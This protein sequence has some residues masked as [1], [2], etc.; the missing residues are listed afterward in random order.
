MWRP[1][2]L[3]AEA[4][5]NLGPRHAMTAALAFLVLAAVLAFVVV[6]AQ[7]ALAQ[8]AQR[9]VGG[10]LVWTITADDGITFPGTACTRLA[11]VP[12]IAAAGGVTAT[13]PGPF[14]PYPGS[15]SVQAVGLTG[16][17][18]QVFYPDAPPSTATLGA[19]L[20][21]LG[22]VG[23]GGWLHD[24]DGDRVARLDTTVPATV[25]LGLLTSG[26]T[27]PAPAD[28][29]LSQCW[30][31]TEPGAVETGHDVLA[32]TFTG[33]PATIAPFS[34]PAADVL[35]PA[36]QWRAAVALQPWA[37]GAILLGLVATL[38]TWSRRTELAVYRAFGT[39]TATLTT[40]VAVELAL[41][42]APALAAAV[43][44]TTTV[45][46]ATNGGIASPVLTVA[47]TQ[48]A[49]AALAGYALAVAFTPLVLRGRVTDQLKDR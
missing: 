21:S 15:R 29:P 12:G 19:D 33:L 22:T 39:T 13:A 36:D 37:V 7:Q 9:R 28:A 3:A 35:G 32:Y 43:L 14:Y 24:A 38:A 47:L 42:L 27:V 34:P 20:Q 6:Q 18:V 23:P 45:L 2:E 10:S 16:S 11:L 31:R 4:R 48:A 8:E 46:A 44:V 25:P 49:A 41:V 30:I 1:D 26:V 40:L 5:R 17:A